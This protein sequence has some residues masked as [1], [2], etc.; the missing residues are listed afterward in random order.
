LGKNIEDMALPFALVKLRNSF[1]APS[2]RKA[3]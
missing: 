2:R 3:T 1:G